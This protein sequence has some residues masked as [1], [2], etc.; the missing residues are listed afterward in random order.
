MA[1]PVLRPGQTHQAVVKLKRSLVES[2]KAG[3]HDEVAGS[4]RLDSKTY[5]RS[6]VRAVKT[7]QRTKQL[8]PDGVVGEKTWR[9]LGFHDPVV[10]ER[11][12]VLHGVP[13]EPG[14]MAVDGIWIDKPIAQ[15]L[16][17]M[18][19]A[20][21]W[22][23]TVNSGYRP[24][25]YQ[26]RLWDAAVK[27]YGS[28]QAASKWVARPGRSRHGVKGGQG[29]ADVN[30]GQTLDS[31]SGKLFRPMDWEPWHMQLAGTR[32]MPE[33]SDDAPAT[34]ESTEV[35]QE[36]LEAHGVTIEDVDAS[37]E[38]LLEQLDHQNDEVEQGEGD[39]DD[40]GY[41]PE[42]PQATQTAPQGAA[43]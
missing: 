41:D 9:S 24:A 20:G 11:P 36:D 33:E 22:R 8:G 37:V 27:K 42:A 32:E 39:A 7:F 40:E 25:W 12:P 3:K 26:Q 29:A 30:D 5:G 2:L 10:D 17:A 34:P 21:R 43:G 38:A 14:L 15:E 28:E 16:L 1:L 13:W 4:V 19:K 18:R 35:P 23:G 31:V 6:T